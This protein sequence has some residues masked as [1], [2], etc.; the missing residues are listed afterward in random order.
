MPLHTPETSGDGPRDCGTFFLEVSGEF[1][2]GDVTVTWMDQ[3]R[4][5]NDELGRLIDQA[6]EVALWQARKADQMLF[7]GPL[8]RLVSYRADD[9]RFDMTLGPVSYKEFVGTNQTQAY[10]RYL[11]GPEVLADP[12]GV[13]AAIMSADGFLLLGRRST[14]VAQ[15][16]E[17]IHPVGGTVEPADD[18]AVPDPFG[19]LLNELVEETGVGLDDVEDVTLLGLVRDKN[20]VQPELVFDIKAS[21]D[22]ASIQQA[23]LS[24]VDAYEHTEMVPVRDHPAPVVSFLQQHF[25]ELTPVGLAA[26]LLHGQRHWGS[27]W[28]A[29]ARKSP[30][31]RGTAGRPAPVQ[32]GKGNGGK[33]ATFADSIDSLPQRSGRYDKIDETPNR[34]PTN[35]ENP[36]RPDPYDTLTSR[37]H[38]VLRLIAEGKTNRQIAEALN[39][40]AR[41]VNTHRTRLMHELDI[42]DQASLLKYATQRGI[43]HLDKLGNS[44]TTHCTYQRLEEALRFLAAPKLDGRAPGAE[45]HRIAQR[46]LLNQMHELEMLPLFEGQYEQEIVGEGSAGGKNLCGF[47]RGRFGRKLLLCAHYDH[48]PG[49]PGADDNA[50]GVAIALEVAERLRGRPRQLDIVFCFFDQEEPP[51]FLT[52]AMGS[53][54]FVEHPPLGLQDDVFCTVVMDVCTHDI[55]IQGAEHMLLATGAENTAFLADAVRTVDSEKAP[56]LMFHNKHVGDMSDHQ[57]FHERGVPFLFIT[58]GLWEHYHKPS[59]TLDTLDPVK[60]RSVADSVTA[61]VKTL[62]GMHPVDPIRY[63]PPADFLKTEAKSLRRLTGKIV[64]P[65]RRAVDQ[66]VQWIVDEYGACFTKW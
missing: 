29:G 5:C 20:T 47:Y 60:I 26:L 56:V 10:V 28:F 21:V 11:Y 7:D 18:G 12:L 52:P 46:Y 40:S 8:C 42:H 30:P 58:S 38:Q 43:I 44:V 35:A 59:D 61:L 1:A 48:L 45:G 24:A 57:A 64:P 16:P 9:G 37:E 36:H 4:Q 13:S 63:L 53:R 33:L 62:D 51:F 27:G 55:P 2:R 6:W 34:L 65:E 14:H 50:S 23:A 22:A 39:I 15:Y 17:R 31:R 32:S 49:V 41:T 54:F 3:R 19:S 25:S 66:A